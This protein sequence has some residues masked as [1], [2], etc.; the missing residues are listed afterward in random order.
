M[1][2]NVDKEIG[3][4][5]DYLEPTEKGEYLDMAFANVQMFLY[6]RSEPTTESE[7]L[8]SCIR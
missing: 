7:W 6:I 8:E 4:K 2:A 3:A 1:I 5:E